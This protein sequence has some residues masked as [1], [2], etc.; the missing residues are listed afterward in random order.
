[1]LD[2]TLE[3][4]TG[5]SARTLVLVD[6]ES[7]TPW[8][9]AQAEPVQ[10]WLKAVRF[11]PKPGEVALL[12]DIGVLGDGGGPAA[13]AGIQKPNN[14][15]NNPST[16]GPWELAS[17]P[18][19]LLPGRYRLA[20]A[21]P[22]ANMPERTQEDLRLGLTGWALAHYRF[23]RYKSDPGQRDPRILVAPA[24]LVDSAAALANAIALVRDLVTTPA[25]DMGPV[26]LGTVVQTIAH[27]YHADFEQ[28][29]GDALLDAGLRTIHMVGRA[30]VEAPRLIQLRWGAL[31]APKVTLVGKGV[32]FDT[33]GLNIK[34]TTGMALMK[35][36]MGGAAHA[37]ALAELIMAARLPVRLH[38][39]IPAVENSISAQAFRPGDVVKTHKGLS[40]EVGNTDAEGRLILCDALSLADAEKPDLLLNFATLTGA[41]RVALG[42]DLPALFT[43]DEALAQELAQAALLE[44][45]PLWRLPLWAP[46]QE[47]LASSIADLNNASESGFAGA[48]TAAL[49]L[50]NF[51]SQT[52]SWAHFDLYAW[53]G[54]NKPGR[55]KGGEAFALRACW[56]L[57]Q[58]RYG[59]T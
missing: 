34:P 12:P 13:L 21:P 50:Q 15:Q 11:E 30:A 41:A 22:P 23:D 7:Y 48:I 46:Y 31:E 29:V 44:Q 47:M 3:A 57:L 18:M 5:Q 38:L 55:P 53:L 8:L 4:D 49:Y 52:R 28:I 25:S 20:F 27:R 56:R 39:L 33:G 19:R 14:L 26:A 59:T 35:K 17:L 42:A 24:N 16:I 2:P 32:S 40:V 37:L 10:H 45:D 43:P 36:D 58:A 1:M 51:I 6:A 9:E 54:S